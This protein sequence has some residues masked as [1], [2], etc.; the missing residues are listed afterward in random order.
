MCYRNLKIEAYEEVL[1]EEG[2]NTI[3]QLKELKE[4]DVERL[5]IP[6]GF[7]IKLKKF[8]FKSQVETG[9]KATEPVDIEEIIFKREEMKESKKHKASPNKFDPLENKEG[10]PEDLSKS[11]LQSLEM[12]K[13]MGA[14]TGTEKE[15][16]NDYFLIEQRSQPRIL[17][18]SFRDKALRIDKKVTWDTSLPE[19]EGTKVYPKENFVKDNHYPQGQISV[20]WQCLKRSTSSVVFNSHAFCS[21]LC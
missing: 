15:Y 16:L 21:D 12:S 11:F 20:C 2:I 17:K 10:Q 4:L 1:R 8:L 14:Y 18:S 13:Q 7:R 3:K 9:R 6:P 5:P 19:C